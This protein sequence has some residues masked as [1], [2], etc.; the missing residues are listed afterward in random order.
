MEAMTM[1]VV[2][3]GLRC[4]RGIGDGDF[5]CNHVAMTV[6]QQWPT[7]AVHWTYCSVAKWS[8][9]VQ[10]S[11][12]KSQHSQADSFGGGDGL[13]STSHVCPSGGHA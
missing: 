5:G 12:A 9:P 11:L 2:A 4:S 8:S 3:M 1:T 13:R 10:S 6:Q 7:E